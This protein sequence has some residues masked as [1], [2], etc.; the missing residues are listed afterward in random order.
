MNASKT[1]DASENFKQIASKTVDASKTIE[2]NAI[3]AIKVG[4]S[5]YFITCLNN[6]LM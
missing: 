3:K 4:T 6:I 1:V 2:Q 5:K